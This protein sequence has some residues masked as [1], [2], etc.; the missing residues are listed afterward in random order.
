MI[1]IMRVQ[2]A[3]PLRTISLVVF[4]LAVF[5]FAFVDTSKHIPFLAI[6]NP[7]ADDPYDAVGSFGIQLSF[8][9][10]AISLFRAFRPYLAKEIPANQ[11]LL[12][13]RG[14]TVALLAIFVT[15]S[16]DSVALLRYGAMW[17]SSPAGWI[18]VG[19]ISVLI[20][21][22]IVVSLQL[23]RIVGK[24]SLSFAN[25][26]WMRAPLFLISILIFAVY[27]ASMLESIPG[28]IFSALLGMIVLF[29]STWALATTIFPQNEANFEDIFDDLAAIYRK[30][31]S[32]IR[33]L[34]QLEDFVKV[35]WLHHH[36]FDALNL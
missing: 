34:S 16:A 12:I 6:I 10:A 24:L 7:F 36:L 5:F 26:S 27:P 13:L 9:A 33:F 28:G 15:V 35:S 21:L 8:F 25:R 18:L 14:E 2:T 29:I 20:L 3:K 31:K 30:A 32:R 23:Y 1:L 11:L 19:L 4:V 17:K 22:T